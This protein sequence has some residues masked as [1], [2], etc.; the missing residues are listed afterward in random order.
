MALSVDL[1]IALMQHYD[2]DISDLELSFS[3]DEDVMGK[4]VTH[5]LRPGGRLM[6]VTNDNK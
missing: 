4:L 3:T 1:C 6:Q 2:G 5:D